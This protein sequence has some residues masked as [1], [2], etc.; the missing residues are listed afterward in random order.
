MFVSPDG[1]SVGVSVVGGSSKPRASSFHGAARYRQFRVENGRF[2][3]DGEVVGGAWLQG[4]AFARDGR[5]VLVQDAL[6]RV[7]K[8]YR[9]TA[10]GLVDTG[11]HLQFD[12]APCA[13]TFWR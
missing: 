3:P 2:K 11:E 4:S 6:N 13:I 8:L 7:V 9:R 5:D 10:D 12:G 1:R